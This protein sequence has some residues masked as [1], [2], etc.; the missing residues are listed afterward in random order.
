MKQTHIVYPYRRDHVNPNGGQPCD[1]RVTRIMAAGDDA[2]PPTL[3][4]RWP[5]CLAWVVADRG[6]P[7]EVLVGA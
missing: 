1:G 5:V 2:P 4:D 7:V 6:E 3:S